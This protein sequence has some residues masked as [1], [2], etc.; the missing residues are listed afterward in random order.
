MPIESPEF[1][2]SIRD[3]RQIR[4]VTGDLVMRLV[5]RGNRHARATFSQN[6]ATS[7]PNQRSGTDRPRSDHRRRAGLDCPGPTNPA[8]GGGGDSKGR[9]PRLLRL[10]LRL[11]I[12]MVDWR[13][14][15][16]GVP[17][18][19]VDRLG[20][21]YFGHVESV[22]LGQPGSPSALRHIGQ[23][24]HVKSLDLHGPFVT[25]AG[26]AHLEG[27]TKLSSQHRRQDGRLQWKHHVPG[28]RASPTQGCRT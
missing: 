15:K 22:A 14:W 23:L 8:R 12:G 3:L 1:D 4:G 6:L 7:A 25:D 27:L 17:K 19:L 10:G 13:R 28:H 20:V 5:I 21:D 26:L 24:S 2:A 16:P 18:W 11:G 9:R